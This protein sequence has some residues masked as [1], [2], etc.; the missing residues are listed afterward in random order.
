MRLPGSSEILCVIAVVWSMLAYDSER[1]IWLD[2]RPHPSE[3]D[4]YTWQ[5]FS[6][7]VWSGNMLTIT[8]THLKTPCEAG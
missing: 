8:T 5:G 1:T 2:G 6:T 7:G 4:R 3:N